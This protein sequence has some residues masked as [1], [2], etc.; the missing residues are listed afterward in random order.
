[1]SDSAGTADL[2]RGPG[3]C[4]GPGAFAYAEHCAPGASWRVSEGA[5]QR[6][7]G[8]A[9][10]P[11]A[12]EARP[13]GRTLAGA[14]HEVMRLRHMSPRTEETYLHWMRR[15]VAFHGGAHPTTLGGEHVRAFLSALATRDRV[16]AA[17][18]N[19]ALAALLFLYRD[20]YCIDLP[21]LD[22]VERAK[23]PVRI[24][25][26]LSRAEVGRVLQRMDGLPQ[27]MATLLYGSGLRLL[28][29]CRLRVKDVDFEWH[30]I[31]VRSGKGAKDR[32]T[33]LPAT[34]CVP[35]RNH[36][37][38]WAQRHARDVAAGAGWVELPE[39]LDRKFPNAGHEWRWQWIF[40]ATRTYRHA[41][42][43]HVRRHH[44]HETV[45]QQ[46]VRAAAA[47]AGLTKRVTCHT[48]RHSFATHL[49][50]AG[51]DIRTVQELLGHSDVSTTMIYT[52]VLGRGPSGVLSPADRL[53]GG[54][55]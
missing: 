16:A 15:F 38:S 37:A 21:W 50:E 32:R 49:L 19:Q 10:A 3:T 26:V 25:V 44:L 54:D 31:V 47:A 46:A 11:S 2:P 8:G 48:F 9:A 1:M 5:V 12:S 7:G 40:P 34:V 42:S 14:V 39:A 33:M 29:C 51:H 13:C 45:L 17:T 55:P 28:E 22:G 24:P 4:I 27:F 23:R 52:H 20:V 35:L 18:Q 6:A 53:L 30:E 43:G 36:L 41:E